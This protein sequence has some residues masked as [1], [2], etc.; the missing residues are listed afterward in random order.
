[1]CVRILREKERAKE[2]EELG[3]PTLDKVAVVTWQ[4]H[5]YTKIYEGRKIAV[6]CF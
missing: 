6:Y 1:M 3:P 4:L 2:E 5:V